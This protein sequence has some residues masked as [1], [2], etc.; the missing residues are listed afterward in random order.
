[1]TATELIGH[2]AG[3]CTTVAFVPQVVKVWRSKSARDVSL[4]MYAVFVLGLA[5][6][7]AYGW[8]L[9]AWPIVI[10]NSLTIALAGAVLVLK[11]RYDALADDAR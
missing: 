11:L 2:L 1:M 7:L 8:L 10:A 6:W 4:G 3:F 9:R 5:L